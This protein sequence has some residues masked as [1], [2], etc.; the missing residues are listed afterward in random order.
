MSGFKQLQETRGESYT[1]V[2]VFQIQLW[3]RYLHFDIWVGVAI[4]IHSSQ[5][6][7][8]HNADDEAVLLR[9]VHEGDQNTTAFLHLCAIF[10]CLKQTERE[11]QFSRGY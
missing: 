2:G 1:I 7:T 8:S 10:P 5:V 11:E 3:K 9:A 6:D 4:S